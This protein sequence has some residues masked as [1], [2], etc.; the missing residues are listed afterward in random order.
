MVDCTKSI[1]AGAELLLDLGG[2]GQHFAYVSWARGDQLGLRFQQPFDITCLAQAEPEVA[3]KSWMRPEY[4]NAGQDQDSPWAE[5]W[6]RLSLTELRD[7]LEGF[8]KR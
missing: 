7:R 5:P 1:P 8:M 6:E 3:P 4:L 2:A